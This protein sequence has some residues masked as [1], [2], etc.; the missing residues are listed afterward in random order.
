MKKTIK[1]K[2]YSGALVD[3]DLDKLIQSLRNSQ[4]NEEL[5]QSIAKEVQNKL[6]NGITTKQIYQMA[7][8]MLKRKTT[9]SASRYKLKKA[10]MELGPSGFPFEKFIGKIVS[11][12]GFKTEIGVIVQ[13]H[14]VTHEVDVVAINDPKHYMIECK[15][16][17]TQG[18]VNNVR[19]PL[20]IQ[21]RFKDIEKQC[22]KDEKGKFNFH[23]GWIYTNTRFTSDAIDYAN[24]V[25]LKLVSWG[26]PPGN[27]LKDKINKYHL[28][29]ITTLTALTKSDKTKLLEKGFVL[30]KEVCE[31]PQILTDV[32][33]DKKK[34]K[35]ILE[36][37][38]ELSET[39]LGIH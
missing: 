37:A 39:V 17:N 20:Y 15:Y 33:I 28:F 14:C 5:V 27:S 35:K 34:H 26:Y 6:F 12:E 2:K 19:I 25:N 31:N 18:R 16:H 29:P 21:S 1:I 38:K 9:P 32:G 7:Y 4:A 22:K 13:G 36:N 3:F 8:K 23:Q 10:I 11:H 30:C 24:C